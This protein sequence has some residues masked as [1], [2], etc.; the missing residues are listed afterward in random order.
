MQ[1]YDVEMLLTYIDDV[2]FDGE[3]GDFNIIALY[4]S[5]FAIYVLDLDYHIA[6]YPM[7]FYPT[8]PSPLNLLKYVQEYRKAFTMLES[9]YEALKHTSS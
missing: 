6:G 7:V 8:N 2:I 3:E 1:R 4:A 9:F 5:Y